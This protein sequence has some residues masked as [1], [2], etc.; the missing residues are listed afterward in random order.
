MDEHLVNR[1]SVIQE[2]V[3]LLKQMGYRGFHLRKSHQK[4]AEVFE[5]EASNAK[6]V[7][8]EADGNTIDEAYENLIEKIDYTLDDL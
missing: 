4:N 3:N 5:V 2:R 1:E 8:L 7:R 6:E